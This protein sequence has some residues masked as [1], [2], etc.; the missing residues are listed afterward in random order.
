MRILSPDM[1]FDVVHVGKCGGSTVC[2]ELRAKNY[3]FGYYHMQRPIALPENRY[4]VLARDPVARF[5]SA[6]NWRKRLYLNGT[7]PPAQSNGPASELRH[8]TELEFLLLF[9]NANALAEQIN[10]DRTKDVGATLAL[11]SL[12]GHV[13]QGFQ[14]YLDPL[15]DNIKPDQIAGVICME[16]FSADFDTLFGFQPRLELNRRQAEEK[17]YI[18]EKGRAN[19]VREFKL[20][21]SVLIKLSSMAAK[22]G[23]PM[24]MR[25]DPV[26][27]AIPTGNLPIE[28]E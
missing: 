25:Y 3:R 17:I 13:A 5:V 7:L 1:Q 6:F 8:R 19:L 27:G 21:Y 18:S 23:A 28:L 11:M 9:E 4:V 20:E 16:R 14:W 15:L 10:T 12:I 22:S 2:S 24:S 26:L